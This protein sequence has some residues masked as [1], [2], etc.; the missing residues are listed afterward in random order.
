MNE[1]LCI[2][3]YPPR[4]C[5]IATFSDDLIRAVHQKFGD[6]Y[7]FRVCAI[8]SD[9]EHH[10]YSRIV[11]YTLN[12]STPSAFVKTA[13]KISNDREIRL[14][15]VQHEFGL[16]NEHQ[17]E[18]LYFLNSI[19][20]PVILVFHTVLSHPLTSLQNYVR[21]IAKA[22]SAIIV[23]T[24][25]SSGILQQEYGISGDKIHIIPH[26]TH[27]V[28]QQDKRKLK[29]KY[30]LADRRVLTTFGLLSAGKSIETT[31]DAL[32][33]IVRENPAVIFLV[34][35]KTHPAVLKAEGEKYRKMLEDK[36][37]TL[38]IEQ[39]VRFINAYLDL[40]VLLEYLQL[41][42]IYLFTSS[43]PNQA[44]SG[45]FVYALG[46]GC[47]I[48]ATPIPHARELLNNHSGMIFDFKSSVQLT[49]AVNK[50]LA[51]E[52]L[53]SKMRTAG[54]QKI[55]VTA[56]ENSAIAHVR[57]FKELSADAG[58]T[59]YSLPPV[60]LAHIKR[61]SR[62]FGI[63]QFSRGNRPD[64]RSGFTLDDN[65]RALIAL[66]GLY[67]QNRD[68]SCLSFMRLYLNFIGFCQ[69]RD[70]TFLN[71]VDKNRNFTFQNQ[72]TGLDDSTGRA[73][74]A[75]GYLIHCGNLLPSAWS[76]EAKRLIAIAFPL[77][78]NIHSPRAISYLLKGLHFYNQTEPSTETRTLIT[79]LANRLCGY[80]RQTA[81]PGWLWFE[82]SLTYDNSTLPEGLLYAW[83]SIGDTTYRDIAR[84]SFD[85]L[86]QQIFS[87]NKIQVVSNR[88]WQ[89]KGKSCE[90]F[91]EQPVD[92]ANTVIALSLFKQVFQE[93]EYEKKQTI[94]FSWFLGN[95][96]LH[97]II[98]NP[99]TGGCYDGLE[100]HNVNLNQGA[101]ST[102]SYL[103]ARLS[104]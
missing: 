69:Q 100:E 87:G 27:L 28:A 43:D 40:P 23:M 20:V 21:L 66:C 12:T 76:Q 45:T 68:N 19:T 82:E 51:S 92:I 60:N 8:E 104:F 64:I 10:R 50:L 41:T 89:F 70:G 56:W 88:G 74:F 35:G 14:V 73:I 52:T 31:L 24:N 22:C 36:V 55:M 63:I 17:A 30:G 81:V 7:R 75:L 72:E 3:T 18:F 47:P 65:A 13:E 15:L 4:E 101:E 2:S 95:N 49:A 97:Q 102:V 5:G 99:A 26:G 44:V 16:F 91:G 42:D 37:H 39:Y 6:S 11:K 96:H 71:Y 53:R 84:E 90:R 54:L 59:R 103:M 86:L 48:I 33:G 57:L 46:C 98:Y 78:H 25:H 77:L 79:L 83:L 32:P 38:G 80:Y 61:M 67:R 1:I 85:F 93:E 94:A 58:E 9:S 62:D 34:I 29:E